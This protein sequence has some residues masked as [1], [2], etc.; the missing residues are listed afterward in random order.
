MC[1]LINTLNEINRLDITE[2]MVREFE[3]LAIKPI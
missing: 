3:E 1:V 2:E